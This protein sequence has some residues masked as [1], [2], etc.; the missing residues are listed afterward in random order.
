[1]VALKATII[2]VPEEAGRMQ[3]RLRLSQKCFKIP[4]QSTFVIINKDGGGYVHGVAKEQALFN[5]AFFQAFFYLGSNIDK[6]P[7]AFYIKS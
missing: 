5:T 6:G 1:M 3:T 7:P 4:V 2:K